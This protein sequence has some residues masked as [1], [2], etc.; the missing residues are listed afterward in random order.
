MSRAI[1]VALAVVFL[2][3]ALFAPTDWLS[4]GVWAALLV[5]CIAW[6][7]VGVLREKEWR[8]EPLTRIYR[9][10]LMRLDKTGWFFRSAFLALFVWWLLHWLVPSSGA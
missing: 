9:D 10:R 8:Q 7:L 2:V 3:V 5:A 1:A 6:E 4:E